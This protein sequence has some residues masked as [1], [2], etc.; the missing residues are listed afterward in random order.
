MESVGKA[1]EAIQPLEIDFRRDENKFFIPSS[2]AGVAHAALHGICEQSGFTKEHFAHP[3]TRSVYFFGDDIDSLPPGLSVRYREHA[4]TTI[5]DGDTFG[6]QNN[7]FL[8]LKWLQN[9]DHRPPIKRKIRMQSDFSE[10]YAM[11]DILKNMHALEAEHHTDAET[12]ASLEQLV[13]SLPRGE[14]DLV[15]RP[16]FLV[17]YQRERFTKTVGDKKN[18]LSVDSA[19][20]FYAMPAATDAHRQKEHLGQLQGIIAEYKETTEDPAFQWQL[21]KTLARSNAVRFYGKKG[22]ALNLIQ[23]LRSTDAPPITNEL[24]GYEMEAKMDLMSDVPHV[25]QFVGDLFTHFDTDHSQFVITPGFRYVN[26]Q[27]TMAT[28]LTDPQDAAREGKLLVGLEAKFASK[29]IV[30]QDEQTGLFVRTEDKGE[31]F[32]YDRSKARQ[33][34]EGMIVGGKTQRIRRA[35][36]ISSRASDRVYKVSVDFNWRLPVQDNRFFSQVEVEYTGIPVEQYAHT[37]SLDDKQTQAIKDE[38]TH[39]MGEINEVADEKQL[40]HRV[41]GRKVDSL[42]TS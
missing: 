17:E 36:Y 4:D 30:E 5:S 32:E 29:K 3:L 20:N 13:A 1:V 39:A 23:R 37:L 25:T 6:G 14:A 41:G 27:S 40:A 19:V 11:S 24:P 7:G 18:V 31:R 33:A 42:G 35:F 38:I 10:T 15:L 12:V 21:T 22:E 16:F 9:C 28:Y 34:L 2:F 8:E 26:S